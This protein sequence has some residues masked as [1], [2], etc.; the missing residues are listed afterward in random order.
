[1][2]SSTRRWGLLE[3]FYSLRNLLNLS[4]NTLYFNVEEERLSPMPPMP[5][6]P[7]DWIETKRHRYFGE[8]SGH[9]HY[10]HHIYKLENMIS[11]SDVY[12]MEVDYSGW[13]L[14]FHLDLLEFSIAVPNIISMNRGKFKDYVFSMLCFVRA[15]VEEGESYL[16]MK[17]R[18]KIIRYNFKTRT[19]KEIFDIESDPAPDIYFDSLDD[20]YVYPY[21]ESLAFV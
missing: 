14:K 11:Y 19:C 7:D 9:L 13:F 16:V 8:S 5:L 6:I 18:N 21:I 3:W 17:I 10:I 12:E 1:M 15:E 20:P 2:A 4:S